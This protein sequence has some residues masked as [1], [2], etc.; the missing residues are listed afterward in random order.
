MKLLNRLRIL[1]PNILLGILSFVLIIPFYLK[2]II[3][4]PFYLLFPLSVGI[5]IILGFI[6]IIHIIINDIIFLN[7]EYDY[8]KNQSKAEKND[9]NEIENI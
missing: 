7:V 2:E 8:L 3:F 5:S 6:S 9:L 1:I 4:A